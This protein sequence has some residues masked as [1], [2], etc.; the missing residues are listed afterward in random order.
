MKHYPSMRRLS[1]QQEKEMHDVLNLR[2]NNKLLLGMI[3]RK[4]GKIHDIKRYSKPQGKGNEER[5]HWS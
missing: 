5:H 1:E 2:P 4:F 3:E